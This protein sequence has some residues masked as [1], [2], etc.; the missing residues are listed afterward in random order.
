MKNFYMTLL[1]NSSMDY[2]PENRTSSFTVQLP[3]YM[4]L[5][6]H[7]EVALTEIQYPYT[8]SNV[9]DDQAEFQLET[10]EITP[11]FIVWYEL[12]QD[13]GTNPPF[14]AILSTQAIVPG[15]YTDIKDVIETLNTT[16]AAT[17][18]QQTFFEYSTLAHRT[19]TS[20]DV[21]EVGRKW[22]N[23]CKLSPRLGLQLGYPPDTIIQGWPLYA[24]HVSNVAGIIPDKMLIYC[25][26]LEPQLFGDS[27][28][29]VLRMIN[30]DSGNNLPY[31]GQPCSMNFNQPQYT[32]IQ[33][34]HFESVKIDIRDIA[35]ELM[36]FQYGTLS[37]KLHFRNSKQN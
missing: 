9:A 25:D 33:Q 16:I 1:S 34:K 14:P 22:I 2:Y 10:I 13:S 8:F 20:N 36:A 27:W 12:N 26:I 11:E 24:P 30:T 6:G 35:G 23:S 3:R 4:Y 32:P 17:T 5:D 29:R 21:I 7:W 28:A 18:G 15:F 31:F 37:V 19:A